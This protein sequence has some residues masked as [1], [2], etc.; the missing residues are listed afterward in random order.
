MI[1][2]KPG[3]Q[4][5]KDPPPAPFSKSTPTHTRCV[6]VF[7]RLRSGRSI[8]VQVA[9][10]GVRSPWYVALLIGGFNSVPFQVYHSYKVQQGAKVAYASSHVFSKAVLL[11]ETWETR[12][13]LHSLSTCSVP[14][15]AVDP[16]PQKIRTYNCEFAIVIQA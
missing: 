9:S 2:M 6:C 3:M 16:P 10:V 14:C 15:E 7:V 1:Y 12:D 11:L 4:G 13:G 8:V 5:E